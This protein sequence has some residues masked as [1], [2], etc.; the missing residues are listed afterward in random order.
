MIQQ[1]GLNC[2]GGIVFISANDIERIAEPMPAPD[3]NGACLAVAHNDAAMATRETVHRPE[4]KKPA[5]AAV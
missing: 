2:A 1:L 5:A 4:L 3:H